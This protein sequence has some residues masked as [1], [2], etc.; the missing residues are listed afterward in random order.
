M[1]KRLLFCCALM[2][3]T[4]SSYAY[5]LG[6][7]VFTVDAKYK[8][9]G[10]NL[11]T[12]GDFS[13]NFDGWKDASSSELNPTFWSIETGASETGGNVVQSNDGSADQT[14]NYMFQSVP[15]EPGKTYIISFKVK[16]VDPLTSSITFGTSNYLDVYVNTDGSL[17]K[18]GDG[19]VQ[20]ATTSG[21]TGD[22]TSYSYAFTDKVEGGSNGY[23]VVGF[24]QLTVGTQVSD[25]EIREA[26]QVFDTRI[27]DKEFA[28][29]ESL[30]GVE[31][32]ANGR[33]EFQET[34]AGLK[35]YLASPEMENPAAAED[36]MN[37][38]FQ[39]QEA[40]LNANSYDVSAYIDSKT[41]WNTKV[42]KAG[43]GKQY[44]DWYLDGDARWFHDPASDPYIRH[45]IQ[46][47]YNLSAGT[48]K[49][50]KML[51]PG[52]YFF[53][54]ESKG[55][56][57]AGSS[58]TLGYVP[59]YTYVVEGAAVFIGNDS[60]KFNLDQRNFERHFVVADVA[61]GETLNAGFWHPATS[62]DNN[63]GGT[64]YMQAPVLRIL[65]DNSE[66]QME[67]YIVN[68]ATLKDIETQANALRVMLDSA[69]TVK[70]KA[71]F[72]WGKDALQESIT[73][74]EGTYSSLSVIQPGEDLFAEAADSLMQ[75]MRLVRSAIQ[76]YYSLNEP[77][78]LL[79]EQVAIAQGELDNPAN[80]NAQASAR[81]ALQEGVNMA[82][83]LISGVTSEPQTDEFNTAIENLKELTA[84]FKL[85][86]ASYSN[87][88]EVE[89]VNADFTS[90]SGGN[91]STFSATG[92]DVIN[93][94]GNGKFAYGTS[95]D[96]EYGSRITSWRGY[97]GNAMNKI[98]QSVTLTHKGAYEFVCQ[99]YAN[100]E[101]G[102]RD[103]NMTNEIK[104]GI[105]AYAKLAESA[106]SIGAVDARTPYT[107]Q[108]TLGYGDMVPKWVVITYNKL[109]EG[110][111]VVEIGLDAL[112]LHNGFSN[113]YGFGSDRVR[114]CGP[115]ASYITDV[116]A[117]LEAQVN[118]LEGLWNS[119]SD[120]LKASEE[121]IA[122]QEAIESAKLVLAGT[123]EQVPGV[124]N[125]SVAEDAVAGAQS[126]LAR[127][128]KRV[129]AEFEPVVTGI[130]GVK[131]D[132]P[133]KVQ[134]GV[135][136][137]SGVK[138]A[139]SAENL[140]KGLYIVDGKKVIVK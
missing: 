137:I 74:Y 128:L 79:K 44:G 123:I 13:S 28:Y 68:Y 130:G 56:R 71:E 76:A 104:S 46:G 118:K 97:T 95:E 126:Q 111:E 89:I 34:L 103:G 135:F 57:M 81:Q 77:Y 58:K 25:V 66:G 115:H 55:H 9:V 42:Q 8:V 26:S 132:A 91:S 107:Y 121:G 40:F 5:Q 4:L 119:A 110:E 127:N 18:E 82:N 80:A 32:F 64:V 92:W 61:E 37:S 134:N 15:Y 29:S 99:V 116:K 14:G 38:F 102:T 2:V 12:N 19:F 6:D 49:I 48:A 75:S 47:S 63:L 98:S 117:A 33:D 73:Y 96:F 114:Y 41:I 21:V 86:V 30:L 100:N 124:G 60:V 65:G 43:G 16:G 122:M 22:W 88:L 120:E 36:V 7:Y 52:K 20:I 112:N 78:T 139:Q 106:D 113:R 109:T 11:L 105:F 136:S 62:V 45:Y 83:A 59:D 101:N 10:D 129:I 54:C 131:T 70:A 17:T 24:G 72:P 67:S 31:A 84:T 108:A 35:E 39:A 50:V 69:I 1:K 138:V 90:Y 23:I 85:A 133:V 125:S 51:P 93:A 27:S 3:A 53:S 87:P 140:P 94:S